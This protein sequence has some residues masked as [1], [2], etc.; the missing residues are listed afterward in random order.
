LVDNLLQRGKSLKQQKIWGGSRGVSSY[1]YTGGLLKKNSR[2]DRDNQRPF[3]GNELKKEKRETLKNETPIK[4]GEWKVRGDGVKT[5]E[6]GFRIRRGGE[7]LCKDKTLCPNLWRG[8]AK[9]K[10][11]RTIGGHKINKR[12]LKVNKSNFKRKSES[13]AREKIAGGQFK[14]GL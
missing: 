14:E 2:L 5:Q 1:G 10:R 11:N 13:L 3:L 12:Q 8:R 6:R 9:P 7:P 4:S